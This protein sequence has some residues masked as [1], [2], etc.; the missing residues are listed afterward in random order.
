MRCAMCV[1]F[2]YFD[3]VYYSIVSIL[4]MALYVFSIRFI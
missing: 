4:I 3:Y 1:D 2:A